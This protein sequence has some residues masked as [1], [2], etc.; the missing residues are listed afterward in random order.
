MRMPAALVILALLA[1][2]LAP[3]PALARPYVIDRDHT[4]ITFWISHLGF[5]SFFGRFRD[6]DVQIDFDPERIEQ[7]RVRAV[8]RAASIDTDSPTRDG[9]AR[10]FPGLLDVARFPEIVFE[11]TD[12]VLT[13]AVSVRMTGNL[14]IRDVTR[15]VELE[16]RLNARG[17]TPLSR[18][19]E[20]IGLTATT[21]IDRTLWGVSFAAPAVSAVIPVRI[22]AEILPAD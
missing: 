3:A 21:E 22:E 13:S 6:F 12:V 5:S 8:I 1:P 15:P 9:H 14:T 20:V 17:V 2:G 18:G 4:T 7:T 19:K 11:S 16:V 10:N